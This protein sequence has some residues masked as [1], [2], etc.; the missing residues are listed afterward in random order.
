MASAWGSSWGLAWGNSWGDTGTAPPP[1]VTQRRHGGVSREYAERA[2]RNARELD[3][4]QRQDRE[5]LRQSVENAFNRYF[6]APATSEPIPSITQPQRRE[7]VKAIQAD[8]RVDGFVARLDE[9]GRMLDQY[10]Q[11][12]RLQRERQLEEEAIIMLLLDA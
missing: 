6:G 3:A 4:K 7:M 12:L 11:M 5:A 9:I 8:I 10:E 1:V 2:E